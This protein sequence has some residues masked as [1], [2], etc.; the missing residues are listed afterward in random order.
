MTTRILPYDEWHKLSGTDFASR[1]K[2]MPRES[3]TIIVAEDISGAI[4]GCW[5]LMNFAH[6]EGLWVAPEHRKRGR[7]LVRLWNAMCALASSQHVQHVYTGAVCD[8]V[9]RLLESRGATEIPP[10]YVLPMQ[11]L[12]GEMF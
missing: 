3:V 8:D 2:E 10:Q 7:V 11:P 4:I 6:V 9:R 1:L 5:G 12:K